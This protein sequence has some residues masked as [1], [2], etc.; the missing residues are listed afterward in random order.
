MVREEGRGE[1]RV[2]VCEECGLAYEER[3]WAERCE[4]YC[5]KHNACSLEI[6]SHA[7]ED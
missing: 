6:T 4:E 7:V 3:T 1:R 2:Y 5:G